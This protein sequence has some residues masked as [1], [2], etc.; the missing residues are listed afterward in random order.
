MECLERWQASQK[1]EKE[2]SAIK[3][4][5]DTTA[6]RCQSKARNFYLIAQLITI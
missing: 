6:C 1:T 5:V 2:N 3:L 4:L